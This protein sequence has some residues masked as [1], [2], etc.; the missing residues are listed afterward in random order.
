[1]AVS[2]TPHGIKLS[3]GEDVTWFSKIMVSDIVASYWFDSKPST[4]K[5]TYDW[6]KNNTEAYQDGAYSLTRP[7]PGNWYPRGMSSLG[8]LFREAD[9]KA[10][11]RQEFLKGLR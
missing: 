1:M 7:W 3:S 5:Y 2:K 11:K 6:N 10:G 9:F 4:A 8:Y